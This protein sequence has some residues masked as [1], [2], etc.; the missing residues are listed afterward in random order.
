MAGPAVAAAGVH[1]L[2][3][4]RGRGQAEAAAAVLLRDQHAQEAC[5]RQRADEV[6]GVRALAI[7]LAPVLAREAGTDGA[8]G[9]V[10]LGQRFVGGVG[11]RGRGT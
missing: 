2:E 9:V 10:D 11:M 5:V 1:F 4:R 6:R 3:H 8:D 7:Q